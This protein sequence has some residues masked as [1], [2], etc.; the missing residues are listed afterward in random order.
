MAAMTPGR[1]V[2]GLPQPALLLLVPLAVERAALL[3][4]TGGAVVLQTGM[5]ARRALAAACRARHV[6]A[7]GVA[8]LGLC[9]GL[10]DDLRPGDVVVA[11][12]LGVAGDECRHPT[13]D[14]GRLTAALR[15]H[16]LDRVHVG[17]IVSSPKVVHGAG[18][19]RLARSGALA[20]D[21]ESAWLRDAAAG[22][23]FAVVRLVV[24]TPSTR[25]LR[26]GAALRGFV[27]AELALRR[28]LPAVREW[29]GCPGERRGASGGPGAPPAGGRAGGDG[30]CA[31]PAHTGPREA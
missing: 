18:R 22:R 27:T 6:A 4:A 30:S 25:L 8:V 16:G 11:A 24:D 13:D 19:A 20:V 23:P 7:G 9:G 21:M 3:G 5:G 14:P 15:A 2:N 10:R 12:T 28:A 26:P 17:H 29:A 31:T 1:C